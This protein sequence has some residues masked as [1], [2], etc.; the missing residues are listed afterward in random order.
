[1]GP[2]SIADIGNIGTIEVVVTERI[3]LDK[4]VAPV[5]VSP[6]RRT[7][8]DAGGE[9]ECTAGDIPGRVP[10]VG[11]VVGVRPSAVHRSGII[12]WNVI[13]IGVRRLDRIYGGRSGLYGMRGR[14]SLRC[15]TRRCRHLLLRRR[16]ELTIGVSTCSK[17]LHGIEHLTL[18]RQEGVAELLSPFELVAHHLQRLRQRSQRLHARIPGLLLHRALERLAG[19]VRI[20][21]RPARRRD[22]LERIGRGHED[23][24]QESIGVERDRRHQ[25]LELRRREFCRCR[26]VLSACGARGGDAPARKDEKPDARHAAKS[27]MYPRS[28]CHGSSPFSLCLDLSLR[29]GM[30]FFDIG[31][32]EGIN[33]RGAFRLP[34]RRLV[35]ARH[36]EKK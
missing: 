24:R 1:M 29:I 26:S 8:E 13:L 27:P 21:L 3:D 6:D 16:L 35:R 20:D 18:L 14:W 4:V 5:D 10:V 25:L 33:G 30:E 32:E 28:H 12:A 9:R 23:L 7:H 19:H 2:V 11:R 34:R 31:Q 36:S 22:D 17:L 15:R